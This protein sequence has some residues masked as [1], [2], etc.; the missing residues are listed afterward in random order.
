[1]ERREGWNWLVNATKWHWF[2]AEGRS[3]CGRYMILSNNSDAQ[4][5]GHDSPD[6][7]KVCARKIKAAQMKAERVAGGA[8]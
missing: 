6:N 8:T 3:L 7:C 4:T 2:D 1:M 5:D